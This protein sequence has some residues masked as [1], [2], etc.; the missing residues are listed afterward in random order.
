MWV[1]KRRRRKCAKR[2]EPGS[3]VH[4]QCVVVVV[5]P[6]GAHG[7]GSVVEDD[8]AGNAGRRVAHLTCVVD[9]HAI[10]RVN[11]QHTGARLPASGTDSDC[12]NDHPI[13]IITAPS[14]ETR[15]AQYTPPVDPIL[16]QCEKCRYM[17]HS[18]S[19][20]K[21]IWRGRGGYSN[22]HTK[23]ECKYSTRVS[24]EGC[25]VDALTSHRTKVTKMSFSVGVGGVTIITRK[26]N[27]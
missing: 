21:P 17:C 12:R 23:K 4:G 10:V 8:D 9:A 26:Q 1:K 25:G 18:E 22:C 15:V 24:G 3:I 20:N 19:R 7:E 16:V 2:N 13:I 5:I 6:P 14:R 27:P 11:G